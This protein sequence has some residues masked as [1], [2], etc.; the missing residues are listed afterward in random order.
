MTFLAVDSQKSLFTMQK[1]QLQIEQTLIMN[2][3]QRVTKE[4]GY[5]TE[6]NDGNPDWDCDEDPTYVALQ[7][8][9]EYLQSRQ[10]SLDSQ[11]SILDN[12]ISAMKTMVNNNIKSSC[13][14]NLLGG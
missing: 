12:S 8:Q 5:I 13:T 9:E 4:M 3:A 14:L 11:I 10:D 7:Q 1:S 6:A 2:R